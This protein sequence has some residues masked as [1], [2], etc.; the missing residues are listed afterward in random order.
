MN[1]RIWW[2]TP[3]AVKGAFVAQMT[4]NGYIVKATTD[5]SL[6]FE[7]ADSAFP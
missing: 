2:T 1:E 3:C 6:T 7:K 5:Y 4:S